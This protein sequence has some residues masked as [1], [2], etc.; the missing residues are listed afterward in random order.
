MYV[1]CVGRIV[2][3][4]PRCKRGALWAT[5]VRVPPDAQHNFRS[6]FSL[7]TVILRAKFILGFELQAH[8]VHFTTNL[9]KEQ[10]NARS[11]TWFVCG[12]RGDAV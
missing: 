6:Y 3:I 12:R 2:A 4:T 5:G 1:N 8:C 7:M 10:N 9:S 11:S